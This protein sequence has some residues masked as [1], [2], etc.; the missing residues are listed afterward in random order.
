MNILSD[1]LSDER[2]IASLNK[3]EIQREKEREFVQEITS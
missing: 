2:K 3:P 1:E